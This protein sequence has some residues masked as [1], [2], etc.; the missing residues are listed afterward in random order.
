MLKCDCTWRSSLD[1]IGMYERLL[2]QAQVPRLFRPFLAA[3][4][5][6]LFACE[7]VRACEGGEMCSVLKFVW[8]MSVRL[9]STCPLSSHVPPPLPNTTVVLALIL[10]FLHL[11]KSANLFQESVHPPGTCTHAM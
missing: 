6:F 9:I 2:K 10:I 7:G 11:W 4:V 5:L 3:S 1:R 8:R